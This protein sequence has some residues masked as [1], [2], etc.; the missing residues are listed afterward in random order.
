MKIIILLI[1]I[2]FIQCGS[3]E[4]AKATAPIELHCEFV[5]SGGNMNYQRCENQEVICYSNDSGLSCKWK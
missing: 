2:S 1:A 3:S 5:S 4:T